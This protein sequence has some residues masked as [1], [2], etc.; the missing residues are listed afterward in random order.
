MG[1]V[2]TTTHFAE[3]IR[4]TNPC[5]FLYANG[6]ALNLVDA[7]TPYPASSDV[8]FITLS[9]PLRLSRP[10]RFITLKLHSFVA[11]LAYRW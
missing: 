6:I 10:P 4:R 7:D 1:L 3:L 8:R 5:V 11:P 2:P 9:N